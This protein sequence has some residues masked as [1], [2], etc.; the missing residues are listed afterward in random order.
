MIRARNRAWTDYV[1]EFSRKIGALNYAKT[2]KEQDLAKSELMGA[3]A[4]LEK[5]L[6]Q[7]RG[8]EGQFFNGK[9]L[10]MV[11]AAYAPFFFRFNLVEVLCK[12]GILAQFPNVNQWQAALLDNE[13]I[14]NSVSPTFYAV[15]EKNLIK[16]KTY[17][18]T[19]LEQT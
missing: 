19:L 15:F 10:S 1:P 7:K 5:E 17:A 16:R 6:H 2:K 8:A 3:L 18:A 13:I 4:L 14:K 11:D 9:S 12:T